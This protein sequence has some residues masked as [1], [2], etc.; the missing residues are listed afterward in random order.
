MVN[1]KKELE[2]TRLLRVANNVL[3]ERVRTD[4]ERRADVTRALQVARHYADATA[5]SRRAS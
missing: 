4:E 1:G 2:S 3:A 5:S